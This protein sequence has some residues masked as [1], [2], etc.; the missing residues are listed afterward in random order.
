MRHRRCARMRAKGIARASVAHGGARVQSHTALPGKRVLICADHPTTRLA[1]RSICQELGCDM[2]ETGLGADTIELVESY[3]P[4]LLVLDP[5]LPDLEGLAGY[6]ALHA[7]R[8]R[9]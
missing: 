4:D 3:A 8:I 2:R 7:Q 1:W 5:M 6:Q 9:T